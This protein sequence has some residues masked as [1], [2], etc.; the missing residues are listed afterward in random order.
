[1]TENCQQRIWLAVDVS[2]AA[3]VVV[4]ALILRVLKFF[5]LLF[6]SFMSF[7]LCEIWQPRMYVVLLLVVLL[8]VAVYFYCCR[9][10]CFY[11]LLL[12]LRRLAD[13]FLF[14]WLWN[15]VLN[16]RMYLCVCVCESFCLNSF[17][18]LCKFHSV[19]LIL[20]I[21]NCCCCCCLPAVI[22]YCC[23]LFVFICG[24]AV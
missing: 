4:A 8:L 5:L 23:L 14:S 24:C 13:F 6:S 17:Q 21:A 2:C 20:E 16:F 9:R 1:M 15:F 22:C 10:R 18:F 11:L 3:A 12:L 7:A 19:N